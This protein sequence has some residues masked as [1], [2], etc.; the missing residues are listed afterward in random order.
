MTHLESEM[1]AA[2]LAAADEDAPRLV[3]A[4]WLLQQGD[5]RGEFIALQC[6]RAR[7]RSARARPSPREDELL[8]EHGASWLAALGLGPREGGFVRGFL[9]RLELNAQ[10]LCDG[11][12][13]LSRSPVR[14][15]RLALH[16]LSALPAAL[17]ALEQFPLL[18]TLELELRNMEVEPLLQLAPALSR[19]SVLRLRSHTAVRLARWELDNLERLELELIGALSRR[20]ST[21]PRGLPSLEIDLASLQAL[22]DWRLESLQ[23]LSIRGGRTQDLVALLRSPLPPRLREIV[24]GNTSGSLGAEAARS[25]ATSPELGRLATLGLCG[26]HVGPEGLE[27]LLTSPQLA[28]LTRL[29][30]RNNKLRA[31]DICAVSPSPHRAGLAS[32]DLGGNPIGNRGCQA[33]AGWDCLGPLQQLGLAGCEIK[34]A[35]G[36]ALAGSPHLAHI[37]RIDLTDNPLG[38]EGLRALRARFGER[39]ILEGG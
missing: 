15:I 37:E 17:R 8:R 39:M 24:L 34:D 20:P 7:A 28:S 12:S 3:Y 33:L 14:T 36:V 10:R 2:A 4:D 18:R 6:R 11:V 16:P 13:S 31:K 5:A 29:D 19:L 9:E 27:A 35:G 30:L 38:A 23:S 25:L 21:L 26:H 22:V 1:L 32:L